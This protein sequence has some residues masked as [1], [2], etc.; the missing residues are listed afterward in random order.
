MLK[1]NVNTHRGGDVEGH[2]ELLLIDE[3]SGSNLLNV[4][5]DEEIQGRSPQD[6]STNEIEHREQGSRNDNNVTNNQYSRWYDDRNEQTNNRISGQPTGRECN[7]RL[8]DQPGGQESRRFVSYA[9]DYRGREFPTLGSNRYHDRLTLKEARGL[10]STFEGKSQADLREFISSCDYAFDNIDQG[11]KGSLLEAVL[12]VKIKGKAL[13]AIQYKDIDSYEELRTLLRKL[14]G[15]KKSLFSLQNEFNLLRQKVG[16]TV[17]SF[18]NR[19]E[20]TLMELI[21][22]TLREERGETGKRVLQQFLRKQALEIFKEGL[23][24]E[25]RI[26][27]KARNAD[28]LEIAIRE[29]MEE[30]RLKES[31][32]QLRSNNSNSYKGRSSGRERDRRKWCRICK[33]E[34]H[35]D[36]D[37]RYRNRFSQD[38]RENRNQETARPKCYICNL[39]G[40]YARDCRKRYNRDQENRNSNSNSRKEDANKNVRNI[41]EDLNT[42]AP[43][44]GPAK[45][46]EA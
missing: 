25:L 45:V 12:G 33:K 4:S 44:Q 5:R 28:Q 39:Y 8:S 14:Y 23:H 24:E 32:K 29:A 1:S 38:N 2:T 42:Q 37:C 34:G 22:A 21:E 6:Q 40:H 16:E 35:E 20:N 27:V 9:D 26:I 17:Q 10:I 36:R 46:R 7:S 30:E 11:S 15:E 31:H 18:G 3:T 19:V 41:N 13:Q 43:D